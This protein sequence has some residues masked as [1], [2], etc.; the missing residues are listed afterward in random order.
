MSEDLSVDKSRK[1]FICRNCSLSLYKNP[2]RDLIDRKQGLSYFSRHIRP[3]HPYS[4]GVDCVVATTIKT[5]RTSY[6]II[7]YKKDSLTA[8]SSTFFLIS[9]P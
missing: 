9:M 5:V 4:T 2:Y 7:S 1:R 3:K 8:H 6:D